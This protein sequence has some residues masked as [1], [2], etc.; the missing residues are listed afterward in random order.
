MLKINTIIIVF[1]ALSYFAAADSNSAASTSINCFY[2]DNTPICS[3]SSGGDYASCFVQRGTHCAVEGDIDCRAQSTELVGECPHQTELGPIP[4]DASVTTDT[5]FTVSYDGFQ[6]DCECA[7]WLWTGDGGNDNCCGDDSDT[8]V[9]G[10]CACVNGIYTCECDDNT[11]IC[12][13]ACMDVW[14][15]MGGDNNCCGDDPFETYCAGGFSSCYGASYFSDGDSNDYTCE[16]GEPGFQNTCDVGEQ[17]CWDSG[18]C[19]GDDYLGDFFCSIGFSG[20]AE[21]TFTNEADNYQFICECG[22]GGTQNEC[23]SDFEQG[24]WESDNG[25]C[26]GDDGD[27]DDFCDGSIPFQAC[28]DGQYIIDGDFDVYVCETCGSPTAGWIDWQARCC[29]DDANEYYTTEFM[30]TINDGADSEVCCNRVDDCVDDRACYQDTQFINLEEDEQPGVGDTGDLEICNGATHDWEDADMD[31]THCDLGGYGP[32][33]GTCAY[34][35][36]SCWMAEGESANFAGFDAAAGTQYGC[37]GDDLGDFY[38]ETNMN[39]FGCCD[40]ADD[41]VH[42]EGICEARANL[43]YLY[44]YVYGDYNN[45]SILP[46]SN[47]LVQ[48]NHPDYTLVNMDRTDSTGYYNISAVAGSFMASVTMPRFEGVTVPVTIVNSMQMDFTLILTDDCVSNCTQFVG[49]EFRCVADCDGENGCYYDP[50]IV[51]DEYGQTMKELCDNQLPGWHK[52]HNDTHDILCCSEGYVPKSVQVGAEVTFDAQVKDAQTFYAG[53]INY[54]E[55]GELY[56]V[57]LVLYSVES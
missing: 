17:G 49:D 5:V 37:C 23:D 42:S 36:G 51:S 46:L 14:T 7:A 8:Y 57:Y 34:N 47:A 3:D 32:F 11:F 53:T 40:T 9:S 33:V 30:S 44:G 54:E 4:C 10:G 19:C 27:A 16:C 43:R 31:Q 45:G 25:Q 41:F 29:E 50:S 6:Q 22:V 28:L 20:C 26:C 1:V 24:C 56:G 35:G 52:T 2:S 18:E 38:I 39:S 15:G 48:L 55:D 13:N 21:G 12:E